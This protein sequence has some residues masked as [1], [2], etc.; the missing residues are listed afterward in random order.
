MILITGASGSAGGAVLRE[1]MKTREPFRAMYRSK[2]DAAK[3]PAGAS[4]VIADYADKAS[5]ARALEGVDRVYLVCAP[6]KE[7]VELESNMIDACKAAGVKHVVQNS[8]LGASHYK[9]SFPSW[10]HIVEEKLKNSGLG[11]T[12]LQPNSFMQNVP[13]FFGPTIRTQN[14]FYADLGDSKMSYIDVGDIGAVAAKILA[15]PAGHNSKTYELNGPEALSSAEVAEKVSRV[16]GRKVQYVAISE[17]AARKGML[18]AGMPEWQ[19]TALID[20]HQYYT[21]GR[22]ADLDDTVQR[23]IGR[24]PITMDKFLAE[25]TSNFRAEAATA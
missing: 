10:H 22:G 7:L 24:P 23:I 9:K 2:E 12:I 3:A 19:V 5:L 17:E 25:N 11:Y 4:A 15:S 16:A 13:A 18:D 21:G 14:A 6:V 1:V 20:L 8:A